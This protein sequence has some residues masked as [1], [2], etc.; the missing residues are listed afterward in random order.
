MKVD[1]QY[2]Q[3]FIIYFHA[4]GLKVK[5]PLSRSYFHNVITTN[6][7]RY[8]LLR[9]SCFI[10]KSFMSQLCMSYHSKL[11]EKQKWMN[12]Q[13]VTHVE[14]CIVCTIQTSNLKV[15]IV[16]HFTYNFRVSCSL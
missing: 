4:V 10:T 2:I 13:I 15:L 12:E 5:R 16:V 8:I 9:Y 6:G 1:K 11:K 3:V 14:I 7:K